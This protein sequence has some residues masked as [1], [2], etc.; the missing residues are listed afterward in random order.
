[1]GRS[2]DKDGLKGGG[3]VGDIKSQKGKA[4][5]VKAVEERTGAQRFSL[6]FIKGGGAVYGGS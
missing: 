6:R 2:G 5:Q 3:K 4:K 1:V